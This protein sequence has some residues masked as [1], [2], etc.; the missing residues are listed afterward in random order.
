MKEKAGYQLSYTEA[1]KNKVA[2]TS[3]TWM[4]LRIHLRDS[5]SNDKSKQKL[6]NIRKTVHVQLCINATEIE[7]NFL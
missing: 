4:S 7:D 5:S 3:H 6:F 1:K 2:K